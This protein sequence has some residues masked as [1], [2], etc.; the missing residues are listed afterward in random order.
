VRLRLTLLIALIYCVLTLAAPILGRAH[1]GIGL[2]AYTES[3]MV[4]GSWV[5][6][7]DIYLQDVERGLALN[8]TRTPEI[9]EESL[10]WS[11]DGSRLA[12]RIG[13][14]DSPQGRIC[15]IDFANS[16]TCYGFERAFFSVPVWLD[17]GRSLGYALTRVSASGER[18]T[19]T[20]QVDLVTGTVTRVETLNAVSTDRPPSDALSVYRLPAPDPRWEV[21][22]QYLYSRYAILML[23][24]REHPENA[25]RR[26]TH[27]NVDALYP[28]WRPVH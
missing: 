8:W 17:E 13:Q 18:I 12:Y 11:P 1:T 23:H 26:L 9:N 24:D 4:N 3:L 25:P 28:V 22:A 5:Q 16:P 7:P 14:I 20:Y 27:P 21:E 19:E 6:R 2:L 15:V 10:V